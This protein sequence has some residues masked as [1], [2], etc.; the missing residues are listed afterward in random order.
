MQLI[1]TRLYLE[2]TEPLI[3]WVGLRSLLRVASENDS[4]ELQG[5]PLITDRPDKK[6]RVV[7]QFRAIEFLQEGE[8]SYEAC[9]TNAMEFVRLTHEALPLP[10]L[11]NIS[12]NSTYIEAYSL[13]FHELI[14][15][16]KRRYL[17][18]NAIIDPATDVGFT[19]DYHEGEVEKHLQVGPME[20]DQL[21]SQYLRWPREG[22]PDCFVFMFLGY[23]RKKELEFD[24]T[25][26]QSVLNDAVQ[27]QLEQAKAI[28]VD[29]EEAI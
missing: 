17:R 12:Y 6:Q 5:S 22:L 18:S 10:S 25:D 29:L 14:V 1:K 27:W 13:P 3:P 24:L 16:F 4:L 11:R 21:Q 23:E 9:A 7:L 28:L 15:L 20:P 26:V 2:F 8:D 19:I